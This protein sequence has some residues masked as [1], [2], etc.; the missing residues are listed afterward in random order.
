MVHD[1][2]QFELGSENRTSMKPLWGDTAEREVTQTL[3]PLGR[4]RHGC[5]VGAF[6][7]HQKSKAEVIQLGW[8]V[9]HSLCLTPGQI[10]CHR[11][12]LHQGLLALKY[13][14]P[15]AFGSPKRKLPQN[16]GSGVCARKQGCQQEPLTLCAHSPQ[17]SHFW[18]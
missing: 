3:S 8:A 15:T 13:P 10:C 2:W 17:T 1:P 6:F 7:C 18:S 11:A 9:L 14:M 16:H 4:K 5:P 12:A